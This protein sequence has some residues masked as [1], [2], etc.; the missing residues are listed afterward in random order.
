MQGLD[1]TNTKR[2]TVLAVGEDWVTDYGIEREQ[3]V[4]VGDTILHRQY[5]PETFHYNNK[6]YVLIRFQDVVAIV[7]E[8]DESL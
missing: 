8:D 3:P 6:E 2:G 4:K 7:T 5:G 1:D